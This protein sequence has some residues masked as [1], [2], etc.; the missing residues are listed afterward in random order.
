MK[1]DTFNVSSQTPAMQW[2]GYGHWCLFLGFCILLMWGLFR[3]EPIPMPFHQAD[4]LAHFGVFFVFSLGLS[5]LLGQYRHPIFWCFIVLLAAL[6]EPA[7]AYWRPLRI[8]SYGDMLANIAGALAAVLVVVLLKPLS[9][10]TLPSTAD[11]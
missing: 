5:I 4:K 3:P 8:F 1:R 7:Q 6:A 9:A 10:D 11:S 2:L